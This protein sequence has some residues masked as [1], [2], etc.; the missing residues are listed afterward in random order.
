MK[1]MKE[2]IFSIKDLKK[3]PAPHLRSCFHVPHAP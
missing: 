1:S 2:A 3:G